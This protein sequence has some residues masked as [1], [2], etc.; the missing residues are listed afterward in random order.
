MD[1]VQVAVDT[2]VSA[3]HD[4][5]VASWLFPGA[6]DRRAAAPHIFGPMAEQSAAV[7]ELAVID[8]G[9][10]VAVW[11]PQAAHDAGFGEDGELPAALRPHVERLAI[12]QRLVLERHPRGH[13]HL[14]LPFLG[15]RAQRRGSGLGSALLAD[16]LARADD[17]GVPAYLEASSPRNRPLYERHGFMGLGDPV[18]LPDGPPVWPMW[19]DPKTNEGKEN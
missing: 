14:Y 8:E 11:L 1:Q 19:R 5:P 13:A 17:E 2:L 15:V 9:S 6:D 16:R 10:A 12:F 18:V 4:D 3:F 7:G